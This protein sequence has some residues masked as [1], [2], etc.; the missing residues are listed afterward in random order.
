MNEHWLCFTA[1]IFLLVVIV[2]M[3]LAHFYDT[4]PWH[5]RMNP[6]PSPMPP[7]KRPKPPAIPPEDENI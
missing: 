5:M 3:V 6:V 7:V 2:S 4:T 1:V